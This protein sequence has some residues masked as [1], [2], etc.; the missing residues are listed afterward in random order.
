MSFFSDTNCLIIPNIL[1]KSKA[2]FFARKLKEFGGRAQIFQPKA[3]LTNLS[4]FTHVIV[5]PA[6]TSDQLSKILGL[7]LIET[8]EKLVSSLWLTKCLENQSLVS[9]DPYIVPLTSSS[10]ATG[11]YEAPPSQVTPS[12]TLPF[13]TQPLA[14]APPSPEPAEDGA[15]PSKQLKTANDSDIE[16]IQSVDRTNVDRSKFICMTSSKATEQATP[17]MTHVNDHIIDKLREMAETYKSTKD[18]WRVF[19]YEKAIIALKA[20]SELIDTY[21]K[22]IA[23]PH[24]GKSLAEKIVEIAESG[25]FEKLENLQSD[26]GLLA[27]KL[28]MR[29]WGVGVET[30]TKWSNQGL[31]S[32]DDV[33]DK[34]N[35]T[36]NQKVGLKYFEDFDERMPREEVAKIEAVVRDVL[37]NIDPGLV[38]VTCGSYRRGKS[39]C[40]DVDILVTHPDGVTH[41]GVFHELLRRLR[42]QG[43]LTDDLTIATNMTGGMMKYLGVCKLPYAE[44]KHRRIDIIVSPFNQYGCCLVYFTGS[45]HFNRSMRLLADK[46]GMSLTE[47]ALYK[48]VIRGPVKIVHHGVIVETPTEESVF[49]YLGIPYRPPQERDHE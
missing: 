15:S 48:N 4:A 22:A 35:L 24:V 34:V 7:K 14:R 42:D 45:A 33:K 38:M 39:T 49:D 31:R 18:K 47:H 30:A 44:A 26:D 40:G 29:I 11:S 2:Q 32:L 8:V 37:R 10:T 21:E 41:Q 36:A 16:K 46:M 12:Q 43:F 23:L 20:T 19:G 27:I 17:K 5:G 6:L 25:R 3:E 28:F 13:K 9:C 1:G